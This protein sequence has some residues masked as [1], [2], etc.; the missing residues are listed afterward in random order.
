MQVRFNKMSTADPR[1][2]TNNKPLQPE[3]TPPRRRGG[4]YR[5]TGGRQFDSSQCND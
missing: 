2:K 3:V 1:H 5:G 4:F